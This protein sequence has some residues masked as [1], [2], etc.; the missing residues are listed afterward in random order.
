[1]GN[2]A[3]LDEESHEDGLLEYPVY[4]KPPTWRGLEV[5]A[6]LLSGDHA[7]IAAW[8]HA[9]SVD[10]RPSAVPTC[11]TRLAAT[12]TASTSV[13]VAPSDAGELLTLQRACWV[14][15]QHDNPG[16]LDARRCT[17]RSTTSR[18]GSR[19]DT[20]LRRARRRAARRRGAGVAATAT[21]WDIGRVMV[22]PDLQGRGLGR[23]LLERIE[24]A[25]PAE[26]TSYALSPAR[27]S[28]QPADVQ[29]GRATASAAPAPTPGVVRLTKPRRSAANRIVPDYRILDTQGQRSERQGLSRIS[30]VGAALADL[31]LGPSAKGPPREHS[32]GGSAPGTCHRG[33]T[34]P[35]ATTTG[36]TPE[37]PSLPRLTCGTREEN[38]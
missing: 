25:A 28:A 22:A 29:E 30:P 8:R 12:S 11:C 35:P 9:E 6:V 27:A 34:A 38:T 15:E 17:S 13:R 37:R 16:V 3:S 14:Q 4:T 21:I 19:V 5:P 31:P 10:A 2:P 36:P 23:C 32:C 33:S 24:E 18:P 7:A 20:V 1:M 26:V